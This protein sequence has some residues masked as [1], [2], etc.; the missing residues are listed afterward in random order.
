MKKS[1]RSFQANFSSLVAHWLVCAL[2]GALI[3]CLGYAV[4]QSGAIGQWQMLSPA[5]PQAVEVLAGNPYAVTV[6]TADGQTLE[7]S[8]RNQRAVERVKNAGPSAVNSQQWWRRA[9]MAVN[10]N[11]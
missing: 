4:I 1:T 10:I 7:W 8:K 5:P 11:R 6:R 2:L 9:C 3:P